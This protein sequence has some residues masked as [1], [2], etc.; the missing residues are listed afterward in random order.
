MILVFLWI[1]FISFVKSIY[2]LKHPQLTSQVNRFKSFIPG[3]CFFQNVTSWK[4]PEY[5]FIQAQTISLV[6][7]EI[8][9]VK[10][11]CGNQ[12]W[13]SR[14]P[15]TFASTNY[16]SWVWTWNKDFGVHYSVQQTLVEIPISYFIFKISK[17]FQNKFLDRLSGRKYLQNLSESLCRLLR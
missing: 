15:M 6:T 1:V 13:L 8:V 3:F 4:I 14:L 11:K 5:Y 16:W 17:S 2:D 10:T 12:L 9:P 7:E